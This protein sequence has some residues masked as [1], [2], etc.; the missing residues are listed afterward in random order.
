MLRY[1]DVDQLGRHV[2]VTLSALGL[3][4]CASGGGSGASG[5]GEAATP[6]TTISTASTVTVSSPSPPPPTPVGPGA[7]SAEFTKNYALGQIHAD[8]AFTAG[9]SGAGVT[10]AVVDTGVNG[11]GSDL[12]GR[13]SSASTDMDAT[14]NT[15]VGTDLHATWVA[16]IL[17]SNYDG[18]GTVGVAFNSTVLSIRADSGAACGSDACISTTQAAAGIDYAIAHG[19]KVINMSFS[20]QTGSLGTAFEAALQRGVAAGIIFTMSA[21][22][23]GNGSSTWP[24]IY[25]VDPRFAGSIIVAGASTSTG[26]LASYSNTAGAA[27]SAYLVAPGD[28]MTTACNN[29]KNCEIVTGTSFA[30]PVVAG[31]MALLLQAFPNL[32][33]KQV[34]DLLLRTA[35]DL[36]GNGTDTTYG[37][38]ALNLA[39]AFSPVGSVSV[40]SVSHSASVV[41][42]TPGAF[43]SSAIGD[44]IAAS[45]ALVTAGRDYYNRLFVVNLAQGYR[46]SGASIIAADPASITQGSDVTLPSFAQ[47]HLHLAAALATGRTD[48]STYFHWM[49]APQQSG[50]VSVAY[51]HGGMSLMAWKGSGLAN[52]FF[53]AAIDPFTSAAQ[54]DQ[55]MRA[56]FQQGPLRF[57]AEAGSGQ[58]LT[59]DRMHRLDGSHYF[60]GGGQ[61]MWGK[62]TTTL[63]AGE[64][65]EPLG[66][67]GSYLPQSSGYALP[68]RTGFVSASSRWTVAPGVAMDV[69]ASMGRTRLQGAFLSSDLTLSSAWRVGLD[70]NCRTL[71]LR[72][73]G[74]HLSLSQPLRIEQGTFSATLPDAPVNYDDPLTFSTR[75][76]AAN[77]SGRE[78]DLRLKA[79][80]AVGALGVLSLEGV[81]S[82]QP[83]NIAASPAAFGLVGGWRVEF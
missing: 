47:G 60:S 8:S 31:A 22:N 2:V 30:A 48:P 67:L 71:G 74:V 64:L 82:R 41:T 17:A 51:E 6:A 49:M 63:T 59:P 5:S 10:V 39:R 43:V 15:P 4:A 45:G 54:P 19:A 50:D 20:G 55:A 27:S 7:A 28:Q 46:A 26:A 36:G 37:R 75:R 62:V 33:G 72:C 56:Q 12:A 16:G 42:A 34:V 21:G 76:F 66:P 44:S 32:T 57:T 81:A 29:G 79:D 9:A 35:D 23:N 61:L 53:A 25:A 18:Q 1:S 80:Q 3:V 14:R 73:T 69:Q 77:P 83:G 11:S 68:S 65:V 58:R 24:A 52:P 40:A 78:M 13:L 70:G 38:G